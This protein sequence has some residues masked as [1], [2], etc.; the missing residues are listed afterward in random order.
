MRRMRSL[1]FP[2]LSATKQTH[3]DDDTMTAGEPPYTASSAHVRHDSG[4]SIASSPLTSTFSSR[5]HNRWPSS[6]SSLASNPESPANVT[7]SPLHDLV[8]D[9]A[10]R[11]DC[12]QD[13]PNDSADE[14]LCICDTPFCEHR[15][16]I[17]SITASNPEW[18]PGDDSFSD[19]ELPAPQSIS[20]RVSSENAHG[21]SLASR[22]SRHWPSMSRRRNKDQSSGM[23]SPSVRS[24]PPSR[25]PSIRMP[26]LRGS[27]ANLAETACDDT[28]PHTPA[29][30]QSEFNTSSRPRAISR[31][32]RPRDIE[33]P[34]LK[35]ASD[36][37]ELASTPLLP[38]MMAEHLSESAEELLT[39][40]LQSPK[41]A[42]PIGTHAGSIRS[43]PNLLPTGSGIPTPPLSSKPSVASIDN[44]RRGIGLQ[45][46]SEIPP[47]T[48]SEETDYWSIKLGH[49]NFHIDPEPYI[50]Q[51]CT[52]QSCKRLLD[53]WETARAEYMRVAVHVSEHYGPTSQT[54]KLTEQ[55]WSEIDAQWRSYHERAN[56]EAGVDSEITLFQPLAETQ[57]VSKL[58]S[59]NDPQ[60]PSKFPAIAEGDIVGPMVQ[61]AK[62]QRRPSS[63]PAMLRLFTDPSSLLGGRGPFGLRS[64]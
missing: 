49:A 3:P 64:R 21:G 14:P 1:S 30:A 10:E 27:M 4:A 11:D 16:S 53:D 9:P 47:M 13:R 24:A 50:P 60:H 26:S 41:I 23:S 29:D 59:L 56:Q 17:T 25:T 62:I 6:G 28:P 51:H 19:G 8:E 36:R 12:T 20:R 31:S 44:S 34:D 7:K 54:Y 63:K 55:K 39:S 48:I 37:Q 18:T 43:T 32:Q 35:D 38:P 40:P 46:A 58:P 15:P 2:R 42:D 33:L 45:P 61:Y 57:R 52:L 5:G 22:L